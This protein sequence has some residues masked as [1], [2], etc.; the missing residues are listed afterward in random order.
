SFFVDEPLRRRIEYEMN[1][2]L[3]GYS[4]RIGVLDFHPLGFSIDFKNIVVTQDA[5]PDPPVARVPLL[6][7]SVQWRSPRLLTPLPAVLLD[8][9]I[10]Y[11]DRRHAAEEVKEGVPPDQRGW[12]DALQAMYPLKINLFR[13]NDARVTY[14]EQ[15]SQPPLTLKKL[16]V[17]AENIRNAR[18][19]DR[20]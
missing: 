19:K 11:F 9:P 6:S 10:V 20:V 17:R 15:A 4:V 3:H 8:R 1:Q 14:V 16:N 2:R 12:Q 5:H 7:A 18:S 13:I